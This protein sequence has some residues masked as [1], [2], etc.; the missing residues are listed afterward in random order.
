MEEV[1]K[2]NRAAVESC[3]KVLGL[4]SQPQDQIQRK[5]LM[6][7]TGEAVVRFNRV[8]SLLNTGL[9]H[10]RFLHS[11]SLEKPIQEMGSNAKNT[12]GL[13]NPSLELTSNGKSP[14][15][16]SQLIPS[17]TNYQFLHHQQT[18]EAA[19]ADEA[20]GRYHVSAEQ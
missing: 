1:E 8:V 5:K 19:A 17:S 20:S 11:S 3:N 10:A 16:L 2:A 7:E 4:L 18:A 14:L 13:G 15:Q 9:G 6:V 12:M